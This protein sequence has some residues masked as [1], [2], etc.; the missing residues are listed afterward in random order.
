MNARRALAGSLVALA[1]ASPAAAQTTLD[2]EGLNGNGVVVPNGYGQADWTWTNFYTQAFDPGYPTGPCDVS[3]VTCAYNGFGGLATI[4]SVSAFTFNSVWLQS[5]ATTTQSAFY[6]AP[7]T[8]TVTGWVGATPT[9]LSNVT[10]GGTPSLFTFNWTG[11]DR[12]DFQGPAGSQSWAF[13]DNLTYNGPVS[14]TP[15]PATLVLLGTG[16]LG[17]VAVGFVKRISV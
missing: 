5:W 6:F 17:L 3:P 7:F 14:V 9:F 1:L 4:S 16:L 15:E 8:L 10:L 2:F 13:M 12:L 11:V